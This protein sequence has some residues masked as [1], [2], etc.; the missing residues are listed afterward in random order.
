MR[1]DGTEVRR[2]INFRGPLT[3][4]SLAYRDG[5]AVFFT[6]MTDCARFARLHGDKNGKAR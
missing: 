3:R 1:D 4:A 6:L 2:R 5:I